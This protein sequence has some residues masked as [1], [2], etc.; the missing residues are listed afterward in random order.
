MAEARAVLSPWDHFE[1]GAQ[2]ILERW[3][4]LNLAIENCWGDGDP[5]IK[6]DAILDA[7]LQMFKKKRQIFIE[8]VQDFLCEHYEFMIPIIRFH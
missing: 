7:L 8:D 3:T 5:L 2:M 4:A 1:G 6:A